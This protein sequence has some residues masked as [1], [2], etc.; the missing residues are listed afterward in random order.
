M[1]RSNT[2]LIKPRLSEISHR[3]ILRCKTGC[4]PTMPDTE[5]AKIKSE[6]CVFRLPLHSP[7]AIF[8]L[9]LIHKNVM[10]TLFSFLLLLCPLWLGAQSVS[11]K[12]IWLEHNV[13]SNGTT[14]MKVHVHIEISGTKDKPMQGHCLLRAS[15]G[16]GCERQE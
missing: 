6:N 1:N 2:I 13:N 4:S 5:F 10:K 9:S 12:N 8:A 15:E 3:T 14:G 7:F 16:N 11:F